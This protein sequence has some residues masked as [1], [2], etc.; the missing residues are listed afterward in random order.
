[1]KRAHDPQAVSASCHQ[2][3]SAQIVRERGSQPAEGF[4]SGVNQADHRSRAEDDAG[5]A[6]LL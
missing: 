6:E 3:F 2:L 5:E 1:M 4:E